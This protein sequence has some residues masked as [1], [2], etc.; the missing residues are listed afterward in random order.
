MRVTDDERIEKKE[1]E[2]RAVVMIAKQ[3]KWYPR[4]FYETSPYH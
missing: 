1:E 2:E 3:G 4:N